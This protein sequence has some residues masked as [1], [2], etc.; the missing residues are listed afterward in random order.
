MVPPAYQMHHR[1]LL[2]LSGCWYSQDHSLSPLDWKKWKINIFNLT[3]QYRHSIILCKLAQ[4]KKRRVK[5]GSYP[6]KLSWHAKLWHDQIL[7]SMLEQHKFS[8][9]SNNEL[10]K[11]LWNRFLSL[12]L[13]SFLTQSIWRLGRCPLWKYY[14]TDPAWPRCSTW[15][16]RQCSVRNNDMHNIEKQTGTM[17]IILLLFQWQGSFSVCTKPMRDNVTL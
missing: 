8:Q 9:D 14:W 15:Y 11:A 12:S 13:W 5:L 3:H 2:H 10:I 7:F 4:H 6:P 17:Y 16:P 1:S